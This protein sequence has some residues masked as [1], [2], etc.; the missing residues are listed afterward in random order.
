[1]A[2][3]RLDERCER[4][5]ALIDLRGDGDGGVQ[6]HGWL[7]HLQ[8]VHDSIDAAATPDFERAWQRSWAASADR[9]P[10][11]MVLAHADGDRETAFRFG[12]DALL[13]AVERSIT[14]HR[15]GKETT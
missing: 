11:A 3:A 4:L 13:D 14:K 5:L 7:A 2:K 9:F 12:I 10:E 8:I 1:M 6:L 15:G